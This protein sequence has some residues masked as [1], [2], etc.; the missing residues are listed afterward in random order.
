MAGGRDRDTDPTHH[1]LLHLGSLRSVQDG[2]Q[3]PYLRGQLPHLCL[4]VFKAATEL[5][6]FVLKFSWVEDGIGEVMGSEQRI[7]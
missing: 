2:L 1:K 5:I 7:V 6:P 3:A 4:L